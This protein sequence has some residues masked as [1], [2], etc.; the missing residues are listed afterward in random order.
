MVSRIPY[1]T[2]LD[3]YK[4]SAA[5]SHELQQLPGWLSKESQRAGMHVWEPL[6]FSMAATHWSSTVLIVYEFPLAKCTRSECYIARACV[7]DVSGN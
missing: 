5:W 7:W 1:A 6:M 4:A 2:S 3:P